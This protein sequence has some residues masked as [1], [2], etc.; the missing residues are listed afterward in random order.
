MQS[1]DGRERG[2]LSANHRTQ[3]VC[4]CAVNVGAIA[5]A[6]G[7]HKFR[8]FRSYRG[9]VPLLVGI[10]AFGLSTFDFFGSSAV[11][12]TQRVVQNWQR[13]RLGS[14]CSFSVAA[15]PAPTRL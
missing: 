1:D 2:V 12:F 15:A 3:R 4:V 8:Y 13:R 6:A 9:E 5:S 10:S 14:P 7:R 11:M